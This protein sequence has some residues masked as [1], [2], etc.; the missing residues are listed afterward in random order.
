MEGP[1]KQWHWTFWKIV[2]PTTG[3]NACYLLRLEHKVRW[4]VTEKWDLILRQKIDNEGFCCTK[5]LGPGMIIKLVSL[6]LVVR[7]RDR[8]VKSC[9]CCV[10]WFVDSTLL[11]GA[12]KRRWESEL[13]SWGGNGKE[14]RAMRAWERA[15][16]TLCMD[17]TH[18]ENTIFFLFSMTWYVT[19]NKMSALLA[20]YNRGETINTPR[21]ALWVPR[22][23]EESLPQWRSR[24]RSMDRERWKTEA[25]SAA[26]SQNCTGLPC[27]FAQHLTTHGAGLGKL[28]GLWRETDLKFSPAGLLTSQ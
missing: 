2:Q 14:K 24:R 28:R 12:E 25:R 18:G 13:G 27:L 23:S 8:I 9:L 11:A 15:L 21:Q 26:R 6:C 10:K 3:G 17:Q 5:K 7:E 19:T 22:R 4:K 16:T 20:N 1:H